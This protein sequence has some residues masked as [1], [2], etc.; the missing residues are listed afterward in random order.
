[1]KIFKYRA[2]I[3]GLRALAVIP[4]ILYHAGFKL[5]SGGY[6]GVDVFFVISG[7]LI[8]TIILAELEAGTFSLIHFWERR[9]RRILPALFVVMFAC[10]IAAWIFYY[11]QD[12]KQFSKSLVAVSAFSSNIFFWLTNGYFDAGTELKPLIH[13]WSLAV[14]EQYYVLFPLF[15]M[16]TWKLG[17]SL[18]VGL[19]AVL[20]LISFNGSQWLSVTLPSF[21]FYMLP[22]RVWEL[23]IGAFI[24]YYFANKDLNKL[25]N[26]IGQIGSL[27][28]FLLI[29]YSTFAYDNQT[30]FPSVYTL[31]PTLGAALI[32]IFATHITVVGKLLGSKLFVAIGLIS[33]SAYLW[34]QPMFAF[35]RELNL[36]E[37]SMYLMSALAVL[38][39]AIAYLS[40]KYVERPFR[41]KHRFTQ[42]QV[43]IFA[44][45][46]TIFFIGLGYKGWKSFGYEFR[47]PEKERDNILFGSP[48]IFT[49]SPNFDSSCRDLLGM[50]KANGE[51]CVATSK[52][53]KILFAGDSH[54]MALFKSIYGNEVPIDDTLLIAESGCPLYP[55]LVN[56]KKKQDTCQSISDTILSTS[57]AHNSIKTV[58]LVNIMPTLNEGKS[59]FKFNEKV[60]NNREAFEL[61]IDYMINKLLNMNK[62][63]IYVMDVPRLKY[64]PRTCLQRLPLR[65]QLH[66]D[67][68]YTT[69]DYKN[70][71]K[72][73]MNEIIKL[74]KKYPNLAVV[75]PL[76]IFCDNKNCKL[77]YN[78]KS[79]YY[80]LTHISVYG[81]KLLL[82]HMKESYLLQ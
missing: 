57:L 42:K 2:E 15:L 28:G 21:N 72:N 61:G 35:A 47:L 45:V 62:K 31:A 75:D 54:A 65:T 20:F 14:E 81:S 56:S 70:E 55:N 13:T 8:T 78:N 24:A 48:S 50:S 27:I 53:P 22:T 12:M 30:P 3:D 77:L 76:N 43:F 29:M 59:G 9:V 33:Y 26:N 44:I 18:M 23:L 6:V 37:P 79:L 39:F 68:H 34:H 17:K 46:G 64:H 5:F 58:V 32:I 63:V 1:M 4:V 67:C 73:Y 66:S 41:N 52:T 36:H 40:W 74:K 69:L 10:F 7:Y 16:F 38:S 80:D 82:N 19:L 25:N 49:G 51:I 71:R 60:L 11:P